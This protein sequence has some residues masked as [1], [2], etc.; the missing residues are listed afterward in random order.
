MLKLAYISPLGYSGLAMYDHSLCYELAISGIDVYCFTSD[1][2]IIENT[3]FNYKRIKIFKHQKKTKNKFIKLLLYFYSY[4]LLCRKISIIKIDL[5][6]FQIFEF[7]P[8]DF[9][10]LFYFKIKNKKIIHTVHD[11]NPIKKIPFK[12]YFLKKIYNLVDI[13]ILHKKA[14]KIEFIKKNGNRIFDKIYIIPH[15]GYDKFVNNA[16]NKTEARIKNGYH[17]S[18]F[19]IGFIG[20]IQSNK[21][22]ELLIE[23][24]PY[25]KDGVK[26]FIAGK[27]ESN[28]YGNK[29]K[30]KMESLNNK[31]INCRLGFIPQEL[32]FEHYQI[33]D[34]L[35]LPYIEITES[36]VLLFAKTLKIPVVTSNLPSFQESIIDG[37][38]GFILKENNISYLVNII[39]YLY[40]NP[41][42]L[43]KIRQNI[44]NESLSWDKIAILTKSVYE[45]LLKN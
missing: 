41:K 12:E 37:E 45:K 20:N 42:V 27:P 26:V 17:I 43:D 4:I 28:S 29:I 13:I 34:L 1:P 25:F 38:T 9:L 35:I 7:Y 14:N 32:I 5:L 15:G 21:N 11:I 44:G 8:I 39:N 19:I 31:N 22:I 10:F 6:H 18:D 2:N 30:E 24:I 40:E 3:K 33:C 16:Q 36:G 23:S